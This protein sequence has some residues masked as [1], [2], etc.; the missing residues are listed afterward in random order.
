MEIFLIIDKMNKRN[1]FV[2]Y[3]IDHFDATAIFYGNNEINEISPEKV[4]KYIDRHSPKYIFIDEHQILYPVIQQA[5]RHLVFFVN[6]NNKKL[7]FIQD[8]DEINL[9]LFNRYEAYVTQKIYH[10]IV[11][12]LFCFDDF[13][14]LFNKLNKT[15]LIFIQCTKEMG[16]L[17][18]QHL[19]VGHKR[20]DEQLRNFFS[21]NK[22][23]SFEQ[24]L[25]VLLRSSSEVSQ[26]IFSLYDSLE[27]YQKLV[28]ELDLLHDSDYHLKTFSLGCSFL[29]YRY[30][31]KMPDRADTYS[32][33]ESN[34]VVVLTKFSGLQIEE[35]LNRV[36]EALFVGCFV[37]VHKENMVHIEKF[38]FSNIGAYTDISKI[39]KM[40]GAVK[41]NTQ[42]IS[43]NKRLI[44]QFENKTSKIVETNLALLRARKSNQA[45]IVKPY[46]FKDSYKLLYV[47]LKKNVCVQHIARDIRP[48]LDLSFDAEVQTINIEN[49]Q[50]IE[51]KISELTPEKICF[52]SRKNVNIDKNNLSSEVDIYYYGNSLECFDI[53][54]PQISNETFTTSSIDLM[55]YFR[56]QGLRSYFD[57]SYSDHAI[58]E[59]P[60]NEIATFVHIYQ[61]D[62]SNKAFFEEMSIPEKSKQI[63]LQYVVDQCNKT[64]PDLLHEFVEDTAIKDYFNL[65]TIKYSEFINKI[66]C[67]H[68]NTTCA[69][70]ARDINVLDIYGNREFLYSIMDD[71]QIFCRYKNDFSGI[72]PLLKKIGE[73][74]FFIYPPCLDHYNLSLLMTVLISMKRSYVFLPES[75]REDFQKIGL[76]IDH[77]SFYSASSDI[78]FVCQ[79]L[80]NDT[81]RLNAI[82]L[83]QQTIL[84]SELNLNEF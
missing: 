80:K 43:H 73:Y 54:K 82:A 56:F 18:D 11:K 46:I 77:F 8:E 83:Y 17:L 37:F 24:S 65:D 60:I 74:K 36:C 42:S 27:Y 71:I 38:G 52:F 48:K 1:I 58:D 68:K 44:L 23:L 26:N 14:Y 21:P 45:T 57:I 69:L 25:D 29:P 19:K 72:I 78:Q 64:K 30:T 13:Q 4:I 62:Q 75:F 49:Y 84:D 67:N 39:P 7:N 35:F 12:K 5:Y 16:E 20:L 70:M 51:Q 32:L 61:N 33:L 10:N 81:D 41:L 9:I 66:I 76:N 6:L 63:L 15:I 28:K 79:T 3:I 31:R 59:P 50:K 53:Q 40:M 47:F 55:T 2:E 22:Q 34:K